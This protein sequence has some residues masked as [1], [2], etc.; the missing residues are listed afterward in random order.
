MRAQESH[1]VLS[2]G[3][4]FQISS[5]V[6]V[7]PPAASTGPDFVSAYKRW[8]A[9]ELTAVKAM[10]EAGMSKSVWYRKVLEYEKPQ[11]RLYSYSILNPYIIKFPLRIALRSGKICLL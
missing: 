5:T 4:S 3:I 8:K 11:Y 10:K 7:G 1:R 9:G 6:L 2:C